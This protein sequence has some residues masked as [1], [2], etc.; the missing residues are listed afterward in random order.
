MPVGV[1]GPNFPV[2][3]KAHT[4]APT[5]CICYIVF[6]CTAGDIISMGGIGADFKN[7]IE[8]QKREENT[9]YLGF[10]NKHQPPMYN[11]LQMEAAQVR[12][13]LIVLILKPISSLSVF[14]CL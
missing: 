12:L 6:I 5:L 7:Q 3:L 13:E 10:S 2:I 11:L 1:L 14:M 9:N 4:K 8:E